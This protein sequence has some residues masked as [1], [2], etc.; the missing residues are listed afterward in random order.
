M[1][2]SLAHTARRAQ[3]RK[4]E[5][6]L[7]KANAAHARL[8]KDCDKVQGDMAALAMETD[9]VARGV[10]AAAAHAQQRLVDLDVQKLEVQGLRRALNAK[11]DEVFTLENKKFQLQQSLHERRHE[12]DVH[13][14]AAAPG[15]VTRREYRRRRM[16]SRVA[17]RP[18]TC[19]WSWLFCPAQGAS[20]SNRTR[21]LRA[22]ACAE[23]SALLHVL[24]TPP[25]IIKQPAAPRGVK[26]QPQSGGPVP[27]RQTLEA[28]LKLLRDDCHRV[29][30]ELQERRLRVSRLDAKF[31]VLSNKGRSLYDDEAP[32]SQA[33]YVIKSAQE[34][35]ELQKQGDALDSTNQR[36]QHEVRRRAAHLVRLVRGVPQRCARGASQRLLP[37]C[38]AGA[39]LERRRQGSSAGLRVALYGAVGAQRGSPGLPLERERAW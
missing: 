35:E 39:P 7:S 18:A 16:A 8:T 32:K 28:E 3:V 5:D 9:T 10:K 26:R 24:C 33:Y 14:C 2:A 29:T 4:A 11:A 30:L 1:N 31:A 37:R 34:R 12:I 23:H 27:C 25:A 15:C 17:T 38:V 20:G 6:D 19:G 22:I 21:T 13:R 36:L